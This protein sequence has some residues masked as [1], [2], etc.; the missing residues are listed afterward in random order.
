MLQAT[1][2]GRHRCVLSHAV[3]YAYAAALLLERGVVES[4]MWNLRAVQLVVDL[5]ELRRKL[6]DALQSRVVVELY[7]DG[8]GLLH[9]R[10]QT[11]PLRL[12]NQRLSQ[13][14][15]CFTSCLVAEGAWQY[16]I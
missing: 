8:G 9:D 1:G 16:E 14:P 13:D 5:L 4:G 6:M 3:H 12:P 10:L 11:N 2:H 7:L 15:L